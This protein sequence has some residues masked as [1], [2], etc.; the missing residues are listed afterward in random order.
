M[1][2]STLARWRTSLR[3]KDNVALTQAQA[4]A[5]YGV[6]ERTW[7]GYENG[8]YRGGSIPTSLEYH[9]R[10]TTSITV[11]GVAYRRA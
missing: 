4:A 5:W 9:V 6:H 2:G 3:A 1:T 7:R 10:T 11:A 8:R